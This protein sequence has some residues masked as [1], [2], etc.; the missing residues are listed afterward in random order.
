MEN[1]SIDSDKAHIIRDSRSSCSNP[2]SRPDSDGSM[3][4]LLEK[5]PGMKMGC[6]DGFYGPGKEHILTYD[7][8]KMRT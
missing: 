1:L 7:A 4:A 3:A 6:E 8:S 2:S 5:E